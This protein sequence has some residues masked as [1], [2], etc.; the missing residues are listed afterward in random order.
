MSLKKKPAK[1]LIGYARV[2]TQQHDLA[3]IYAVSRST[4]SRLVS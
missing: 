3:K 1:R 2:S 4:I